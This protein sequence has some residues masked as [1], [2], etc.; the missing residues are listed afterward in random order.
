ERLVERHHAVGVRRAQRL[1]HLL[2]ARAER[3]RD[4]VDG[5]RPAELAG[6]RLAG[7]DDARAELLDLAGDAEHPAAVAEMALEL[8]GDR[9]NGERREADVA[10]DVEAIDRLQEAERRDLL[11]IL[12]R[13]ALARVPSR[14]APCERKH[15]LG[16]LRPRGGVTV[17]VPAAQ[18]RAHLVRRLHWPSTPS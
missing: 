6:E 18:E 13:L 7:A 16:E 2:D 5:R 9:R 12:E 3:A 4:L 14:Q 17:L 8:A 15:A 11:E 10:R 1:E